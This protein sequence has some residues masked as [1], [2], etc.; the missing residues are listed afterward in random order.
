MATIFSKIK[1]FFSPKEKR[2]VY[3]DPDS[4]R[5]NN[6]INAQQNQIAELHAELSKY[7]LEEQ[8]KK[9]VDYKT[10]QDKEIRLEL[11]KQKNQLEIKEYPKYFSLMQF[12]RKIIYD[13]KLRSNLHFTSFDGSEKLYKFGDIGLSRSGIVLLNDVGEVIHLGRNVNDVFWSVGALGDD[14]KA[15][16]IPLCLDKD[17]GFVENVMMWEGPDLTPTLDGKLR[18]TKARKKELY[19]LLKERDEIIARQQ[20]SIE[21]LELTNTQLQQK[22]DELEISQ[23][24]AEDSADTS[25]NELSNIEGEVSSI[26]RVFGGISRELVKKRNIEIILEDNLEKLENQI[27]KMREEAER[28]GVKVSDDRALERIQQIR[29]ELVRD[30]P[31]KEVRVIQEVPQKGNI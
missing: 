27:V 2:V 11:N 18:Y 29:R 26:S 5:E 31:T 14:L 21:E 15:F 9:E 10:E 20:G 6:L 7:R 19:K 4:V 8:K 28:Q 24:V 25:R 13:K 30:E 17:G 12:C 23:R 22:T 3:I 16:R 1:N